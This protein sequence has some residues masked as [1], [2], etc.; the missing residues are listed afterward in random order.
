M[1]P[2]WTSPVSISPLGRRSTCILTE[3]SAITSTAKGRTLSSD[4]LDSLIFPKDMAVIF[5]HVVQLQYK[6]QHRYKA[7]P[8]NKARTSVWLSAP[9][10]SFDGL[11]QN[12]L[13][14]FRRFWGKP[15]NYICSF[16]SIPL[17]PV[18]RRR[19]LRENLQFCRGNRQPR[20]RSPPVLKF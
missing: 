12:P 15:S 7:L 1:S 2:L 16:R 14:K 10:F 11:P 6:Y 5:N 3:M 9:Y 17:F 20:C 18:K 13:S 8:L 19:I 4:P